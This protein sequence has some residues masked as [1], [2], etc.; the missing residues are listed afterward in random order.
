VASP[1]PL[2]AP[3]MRMEGCPGRRG[4]YA[5]PRRWRDARSAARRAAPHPNNMPS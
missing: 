5:R 4:A 2:A 3:V 1:M